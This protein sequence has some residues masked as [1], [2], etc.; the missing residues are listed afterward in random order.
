MAVRGQSRRDPRLGSGSS[1]PPRSALAEIHLSGPRRAL[2][3]EPGPQ[4]LP[5]LELWFNAA[6][7]HG[8]RYFWLLESAL[9]LLLLLEPVDLAA[10]HASLQERL[11]FAGRAETELRTWRSRWCHPGLGLELG[12]GSVGAVTR[13][14]GR[15]CAV[16]SLARSLGPFR[17]TPPFPPAA[18]DALRDVCHLLSPRCH[19]AVLLRMAAASTAAR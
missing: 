9:L 19:M 5:T 8:N 17:I 18:L 4:S 2:S 3:P 12:T 11:S 14:C 10:S 1:A 7:F 16:P 6:E 13:R 15:S